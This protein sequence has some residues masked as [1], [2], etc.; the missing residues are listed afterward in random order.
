MEAPIRRYKQM[1]GIRGSVEELMR[2]WYLF[3]LVEII[4]LIL[5]GIV[6]VH[7]A[8]AHVVPRPRDCHPTYYLNGHYVGK[9]CRLTDRRRTAR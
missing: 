3:L 4:V 1:G 9:A 2:G 5:C 7:V 8:S 6:I